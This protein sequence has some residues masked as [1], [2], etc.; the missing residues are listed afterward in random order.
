VTLPEL[1]LALYASVAVL[2]LAVDRRTGPRLWR[3][4]AVAGAVS[5]AAALGWG[6]QRLAAIPMI[7]V[8]L[9]AASL[10]AL[11]SRRA[12][13]ARSGR[14]G[15]LRAIG[16]WTLA[17]VAGIAVAA[18]A[19]F[20][21]IVD[22]LAN[23]PVRELLEESRPLDLSQLPWAEA[24]EMM[25]GR[26][27]R[28]YAIGEWKRIDWTSLHDRTAP[29]I[30]DAARAKDRAAFYL[31]LREYLWSLH[32][33]HVGL[34]GDDAGLRSAAIKG[35]FGL[36]LLRLDNGRTIAH[37]VTAE[38]PAARA[39]LSW[40]ATVL[41]WDGVPI[42]D[43][44]TR[45]SVIWSP[46]PP[47]T[48]EGTALAR[49]KWLARAPIGTKVT[50]TYE[51]LGDTV[52]RT[53]T[54]EAED[55]QFAPL[56][57]ATQAQKFS[58]RSTTVEWRV[59]PEAVGYLKIRAE[60]PTLP[61]PVPDRV[62]RQAVRAFVQAGVHGVIIDAR[63]N[64]GGADKLVPLFMG[65]FVGER[66]FYE[67]AAFYDDR[68]GR[69]ERQASGTLWTEPRAP[70][71]HGPIAVLV[72]PQCASSGEGLALIA[73][74]RPGGHVVGYYGTHGSFGMTGAEIRLPGGLTVEYPNGRS[75]DVHGDIQV[76][77]DWRLQGGVAPD[78]RV[79]LTL[80]NAR[81]QFLE[82]RDVV[83]QVAIDL[84]K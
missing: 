60:I 14:R 27:A 62:V 18:D 7:V 65:W 9:A 57:V 50:L 46:D 70:G 35:G 2:L 11:R 74:R 49:L 15:L 51:N 23:D 24:F 38:G 29:K 12:A 61:Q 79:P 53:A 8:A 48:Q 3:A 75:L 22:P 63:A 20:I 47:A 67:H 59:L 55:D 56:R 66:Q 25:H 82:G 80:A 68:T 83:L 30:A 1:V 45:A 76:D 31:A 13:G 26:L 52:P 6:G 40:G 21:T 54:L 77:S 72:D 44:A 84:V 10:A 16:R 58:F 71:F 43:A 5:A 28:A 69:F 41:S 64:F 33:G 39:G 17:V 37:V 19:A 4:V 36:A 34:S 32:D 42:E 73:R 78:V 81:A